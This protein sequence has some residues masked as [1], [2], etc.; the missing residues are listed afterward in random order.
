MGQVVSVVV[1][2]EERA[3]GQRWLAMAHPRARC[4]EALP[5]PRARVGGALRRSRVSRTCHGAR[6]GSDGGRASPCGWRLAEWGLHRGQDRA[7]PWCDAA[8]DQ[9]R[10]VWWRWW[11][12]WRVWRRRVCGCVCV[13]ACVYCLLFRARE[14]TRDRATHCSDCARPAAVCVVAAAVAVVVAACVAVARVCVC[15]CVYSWIEPVKQRAIARHIA[16]LAPDQRR[17]GWRWWWWRWRWCRMWWRRAR[18]CVR[19]CVCVC[20]V[21][22]GGCIIPTS[23]P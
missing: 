22:R 16:S 3:G 23:S 14:A 8:H 12:W 15:V 18:V 5:S 21:G 11:W 19:A 10:V 17:G 2:L 4:V 20:C 13:R 7:G 6:G 1:V 9:R